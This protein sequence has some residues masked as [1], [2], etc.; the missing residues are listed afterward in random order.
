MFNKKNLL[1]I[2]GLNLAGKIEKMND[3]Q[4]DEYVK[5]LNTFI[6]DFPEQEIMIKVAFEKKDYDSFSKCHTTIYNML[7]R[8]H[9]D[10]F[11]KDCRESIVE[12]R[13]MNEDKMEAYMIYFLTSLSMLSIDIQMALERSPTEKKIIKIPNTNDDSCK[14]TILAVDDRSIF[15]SMLKT[16]LKDTSYQLTCVTSGAAA[17]RYLKDR[18]PNLFILDIEMPEMDGIELSQKIREMGQNAPI[19]FLTGNS[20]RDNVARAIKAGAVDFVVKPINQ[21]Q[22]LE[23]ISKYI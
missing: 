15:L 5:A 16:Y 23:R 1:G 13:D 22:V 3:T 19:I 18:S 11:A 10:D 21:T 12:L 4:L 8:I 2:S 20:T 17:L 6:T 14:G 9:A 7:M